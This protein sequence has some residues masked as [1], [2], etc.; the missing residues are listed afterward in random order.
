[1]RNVAWP[2]YET[3]EYD[4]ANFLQAI[5]GTLKLFHRSTLSFQ[6][7]AEEA[8]SQ[9]RYFGNLDITDPLTG[10]GSRTAPG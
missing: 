5:A 4:A 9:S 3:P 7:L 10:V 1:M 8:A 2:T 6:E